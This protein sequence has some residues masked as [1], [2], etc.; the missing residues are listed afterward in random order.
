MRCLPAIFALILGFPILALA[1]TR[2]D[3]LKMIDRPRVS[4]N[5]IVTAMDSKDPAFTEFHIVITVA[6]NRPVP[7]ILLKPATT[8]AGK[9]FP[10]VIALHGTGGNKESELP[11][12]R[13]AVAKGF[14][15]VAIDA[16]YHGERSKKGKGEEDYEAAIL[17]A[18]ETPDTDPAKEHPFFYDTV[19]DVM[20]LID[21]LQTRDDVDPAHIGL[22]GVSK[23]GIETYLAAAI[24]TRIA[25]AVPCISLESFKWALD[26][27]QWKPRT[28]TIPH[29]FDAAAKSA[30]V[31][32][33]D[34]AFVHDFYARVAPQ[35]D[36][37]F[38]GP[39]MVTFIAPRPLM[40]IN[41]ELDPRTPP[42]SLQLCIDA[43]KSAYH[44]AN[45]DDHFLVRIEPKTAH[46]VTPDSQA[47]A[48][49]WFVK[50]L[51]P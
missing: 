23:G 16:P 13:D 3:F 44:A 51:K 10:V 35:L 4:L 8:E 36:G 33:P 30:N 6:E 2:A 37:Q 38:D 28:G 12:L 45:A 29:A 18:F 49:D 42:A 9:R 41:G 5:P 46:K 39:A 19:F 34:S 17:R 50:W 15:A 26:N 31:A 7:A 32:N 11:F 27:N 40:T 43:A 1:D 14:I 21:Y 22:Y 47:A 25:V 24:D 20:R 48:I